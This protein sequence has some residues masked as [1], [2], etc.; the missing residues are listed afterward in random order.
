MAIRRVE[1]IVEV[2]Y[3]AVGDEDYELEEAYRVVDS[4]W[5]NPNNQSF[6][7]VLIILV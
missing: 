2:S 1:R 5:D 4:L 7:L 3:I 6:V